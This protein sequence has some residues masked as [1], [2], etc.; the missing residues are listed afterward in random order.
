M[1]RST[2][3][4]PTAASVMPAYWSVL[5]GTGAAL[6]SNILE[7]RAAY[8]RGEGLSATTDLVLTIAFIAMFA[9][10]NEMMR[11]GR[12]WG[13]VMLTIFGLTGLLFTTLG[14]FHIGGRPI[15]GTAQTLLGVIGAVASVAGVTLMYLPAANAYFRATRVQAR[16]ISQSLRKLLLTAHVGIS[17][18]WLGLVTGMMAMAI[19]AALA[20]DPRLQSSVFEMLNL[21]D[22]IFLG[23]TSLFALLT[24]LVGSVGT[25]WHLMRRRWV[26]TKFLLTI[27][28]M[29]TGFSVMHQLITAGYEAT[30][31][32]ESM[33]SVRPIAIGLS[34]A[35]GLA[36]CLLIFM[37]TLSTYKPWGLTRYGQR[38]REVERSVATGQR[39]RGLAHDATVHPGRDPGAVAAAIGPTL[40]TESGTAG[41]S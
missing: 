24:G 25:K 36:V 41:S 30:G 14:L 9:F 39:D 13:R 32:G 2:A 29:I 11:V 37:L 22:Q 6:L 16:Q 3:I 23:M 26:S 35:S 20:D 19:N 17:V 5:A 33:D 28:L 31:R 38:R 18:A 8:G 21:L 1:S 15:T 40:T 34:C 27:G 4:A 10:F 12:Q 7:L